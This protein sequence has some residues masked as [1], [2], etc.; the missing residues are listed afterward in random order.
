MGRFAVL[1]DMDGVI[2]D[3]EKL[4]L[5][6]WTVAAEECGVPDLVDHFYRFIGVTV[7]RT[8]EILQ[9]LYGPDF[10]IPDFEASIRRHFELRY[11]REGLPVK[12]GALEI[13]RFLHQA[14]VP[15]ALA[16]STL[17]ATVTREL[18]DAGFLD[19]FRAVVGGDQVSRSKPNPDIFL[20][21]AELLN[22]DPASCWVIEDSFNGIRAAHAAGMHPIM[23]PDLL[24]PT[25]EIRSLAEEVF[26]SLLQVQA[27][28]AEKLSTEEARRHRRY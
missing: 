15:T 23:V 21:A 9:E 5:Q 7:A 3:T 24:Q 22:I 14:E 25:E 26:P 12:S 1:F 11:A 2:F 18:R 17:T 19:Y 16:S 27:F 10:S 6:L 13:L 20:R 4:A 8:R 28:F